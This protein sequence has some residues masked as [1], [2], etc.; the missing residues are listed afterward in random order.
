MIFLLIPRDVAA[1]YI[2]S[3]EYDLISIQSLSCNQC[4]SI[5]RPLPPPYPPLTLRKTRLYNSAL[6]NRLTRALSSVCRYDLSV[7]M[8][9]AG[10]PT[11]RARRRPARRQL[12]GWAYREGR[13]TC[14]MSLGGKFAGLLTESSS[15]THLTASTSPSLLT[16]L[17][18]QSVVI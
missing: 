12:I 17:I 2:T 3:I 7:R 13:K 4:L 5:L 16:S 9:Q 8:Y 10:Q 1:F 6:H 15:T 14:R 11:W 18:R